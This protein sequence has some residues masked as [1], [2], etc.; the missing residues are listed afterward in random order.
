MRM[1]GRMGG[2]RVKLINLQIVK[3]V[4]E[5][6]ILVV[7]GAVPGPNNSYVKIERWS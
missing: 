7:K 5:K 2:H 1:A 3:I 6:N 4:L